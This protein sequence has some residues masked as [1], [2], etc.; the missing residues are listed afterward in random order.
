MSM[1]PINDGEMLNSEHVS[2]MRYVPVAKEGHANLT[3]RMVSGLVMSFHEGLEKDGGTDCKKLRDQIVMANTT[4]AVVS[5]SPLGPLAEL[6]KLIGSVGSDDRPLDHETK[7]E[8]ADMWPGY[9]AAAN[10]AIAV[11]MADDA[12][13][14][15]KEAAV[16]HNPFESPE[17][18]MRLRV[19]ME[20]FV[21]SM[22]RYQDAERVFYNTF[23]R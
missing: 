4:A 21:R 1:I 13:I 23:L 10:Y 6:G 17:K 5:A 8:D 3:L 2:T 7:K 19:A 14:K 18:K 15:F 12:S 22:I 20:N 9:T 11:D 16:T